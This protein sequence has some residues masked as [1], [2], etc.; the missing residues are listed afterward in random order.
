MSKYWSSWLMVPEVEGAGC[1]SS[2]AR[3]QVVEWSDEYSHDWSS[4]KR[5]LYV[6]ASLRRVDTTLHQHSLNPAFI[7]KGRLVYTI[8]HKY[9][10]I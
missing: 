3:P 6:S 7:R 9:R 8:S 5:S 2:A 4:N 1:E 10:T